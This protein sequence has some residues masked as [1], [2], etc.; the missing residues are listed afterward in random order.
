MIDSEP[1]DLPRGCVSD[2]RQSSVSALGFATGFSLAR[3]VA[4]PLRP[5]GT[6]PKT[7]GLILIYIC[8][9]Y[10]RVLWVDVGCK[11]RGGRVVSAQAHDRQQLL[12]KC[13]L[14]ANP[15]R[16]RITSLSA[17]GI[18]ASHRSNIWVANA[19]SNTVSKL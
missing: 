18:S 1:A 6:N 5:G 12:V 7:E 13:R 8:V 19:G 14:K 16:G 15:R 3:R 10:M 11:G 4:S 17:D 9:I 2:S